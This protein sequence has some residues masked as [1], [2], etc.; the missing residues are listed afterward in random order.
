MILI[1]K[2]GSHFSKLGTPSHPKS[3]HVDLP[4]YFLD[5]CGYGSLCQD[6][7]K[8]RIEALQPGKGSR[9]VGPRHGNKWG[10]IG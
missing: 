10:K 1:K 7:Q 8:L 5:L 6:L 2:N 4:A 3:L 9:Q